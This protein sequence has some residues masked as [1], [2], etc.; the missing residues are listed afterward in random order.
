MSNIIDNQLNV[1]GPRETLELFRNSFAVINN[2]GQVEDVNPN[3]DFSVPQKLQS[4][5]AT[6]RIKGISKKRQEMI[7][8]NSICFFVD[9][10]A[11][12]IPYSKVSENT[13]LYNFTNYWRGAVSSKGPV[14]FVKQAS[15][16]FD[17]LN[18][19]LVCCDVCNHCADFYEISNGQITSS[20]SE[21][22]IED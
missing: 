17:D 5:T 18:F 15:M 11:N 3:L 20:K 8:E 21:S 19:S 6:D 9:A 14:S 13:D 22:G 12:Y 10:D 7:W 2:E 4:A 16:L 1:E